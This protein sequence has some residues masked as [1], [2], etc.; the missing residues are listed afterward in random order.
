MTVLFEMVAFTSLRI[1]L[2]IYI[3]DITD[4]DKMCDYVGQYFEFLCKLISRE[5]QEGAD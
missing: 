5:A 1:Y 2:M 4:I 3:I